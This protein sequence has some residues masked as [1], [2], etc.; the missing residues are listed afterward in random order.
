MHSDLSNDIFASLSHVSTGGG[1][2]PEST[3]PTAAFLLAFPLVSSLNSLKVT[4]VIEDEVT[5]SQR[6]TPTLLQIGTMD[7]T[8]PTQSQTDTLTPSLLNLDNFSFFSREFYPSFDPIVTSSSLTSSS[9]ATTTPTKTCETKKDIIDFNVT[10]PEKKSSMSEAQ[11]KDELKYGL[12]SAFDKESSVYRNNNKDTVLCSSTIHS[13]VSM[14]T[15][16][17]VTCKNIPPVCQSVPTISISQ[18]IS[19]VCQKGPIAPTCRSSNVISENNSLTAMCQNTPVAQFY[20]PNSNITTQ[21]TSVAASTS[22]SESQ[23]TSTTPQYQ[24]STPVSQ[25]VSHSSA[26]VCQNAFINSFCQTSSANQS[27]SLIPP[28]TIPLSQNTSITPFY[29]SS[30]VAN[31]NTSLV[32]SSLLPVSQG[33]TSSLYENSVV[34]SRNAPFIPP[35][36]PVGHS[37]SIVPRYQD[38]ISQGTALVPVCQSAITASACHSS[39]GVSYSASLNSISH[40]SSTTTVCQSTPTA[41]LYHKSSI[42]S[43][44]QNSAVGILNTTSASVSESIISRPITTV[45][46]QNSSILPI[47]QNVPTVSICQNITSLTNANFNTIMSCAPSDYTL[48]YNHPFYSNTQTIPTTSS[49]VVSS[50][51]HQ[52]DKLKAEK[53][54]CNYY[55]TTT[56]YSVPQYNTFNPFTDIPK[57]TTYPISTKSYNDALYTSNTTYSYNY[58]PD[59]FTSYTTTKSNIKPDKLYCGLNYDNYDYKHN[60]FQ[61]YDTRNQQFGNYYNQNHVQSKE[62][63]SSEPSN[64]NHNLTTNNNKATVNWMTTPDVRQH[65]QNDF[66]MPS[67]GKDVDFAPNPIYSSNSFSGPQTTYFNTN[68]SLYGS[69]DLHNNA[70]FPTIPPNSFQRNE[71]EENQFS[72]SPSKLPQLLDTTHNFV[73]GTLP[74]LVGDL[75][76][77]NTQQ[78]VDQKSESKN[79]KDFRVKDNSRRSK[80][81]TNYDNQSNFL[82]VSQLVDHNKSDPIPGRVGNRRN[83]GNRSSNKNSSSSKSVKRKTEKDVNNFNN[84]IIEKQIKHSNHEYQS[85]NNENSNWMSATKNRNVKIPSS[86]YSAEALIGHQNQTDLNRTRSTQNYSMVNKALPVPFLTDNIIPYFPMDIPQDNT[87][88]QQNQNYQPN[89]FTHNFPSAIQGSVYSNSTFVP[90]P[91][92]ITTS[93]LSSTNFV[94]DIGTN[95][96]YAPI[97]PENTFTHV[98][99]K[100][101]KNKTLGI[102]KSN[103]KRNM[104]QTN[105]NCSVNSLS[106]GKKSKKKQ[107]S[108]PPNLSNLDF[109]FLSMPAAINS[110]ILPDDFQAHTSFLP[111]PTPT[112]LYPCKNPLYSKQDLATN[113]LLTLPPASRSGVAHPEISPSLNNVGTTLTNFNLST[114]F[115]EINKGSGSMSMYPENGKAKEYNPR[116]FLPGTSQVRFKQI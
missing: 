24:N 60:E 9:V 17:P 104:T 66:I 58:H 109:S 29:E 102:E 96:D 108:E 16:K 25:S 28:S 13:N 98:K 55:P 85:Q 43:V 63:S 54:S 105:N 31:Q 114:I 49:T 88:V 45:V 26:A 38:G 77:G 80:P 97:L 68:T 47:P 100:I 62:K 6:G 87:L 7:T 83:S 64:K 42:P 75:A 65:I 22:I 94:P 37:A 11:S 57:S 95:N 110:P 59:N 84:K 70:S 103:D 69:N 82:S 56:S 81:S 48:P 10:L 4:E 112:Q 34:V 74:T 90:N 92:P 35:L 89:T 46:S 8:K 99:D 67:L 116:E 33:G 73:S 51:K 2:N 44:C 115:P 3:S 18:S 53:K 106:T 71:L 32:S 21:S 41:S 20:P 61:K 101:S 76:L 79:M 93:Y 86:S 39:T 111:P 12:K 52:I 36:A 19:S 50:T 27:G 1:Q 40:N 91:T 78:F 107:H 23:N 5:E 30:P 14:T 113:S 15:C 72:W